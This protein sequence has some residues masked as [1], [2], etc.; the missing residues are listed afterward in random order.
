MKISDLVS[1]L[2]K[3]QQKHGDVNIR[4]QT[5]DLIASEVVA[6]DLET[7][8]HFKV[9][10]GNVLDVDISRVNIEDDGDYATIVPR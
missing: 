6:S 5:P 1:K 8:A 7:F 4:M 3:I 9:R 2:W 10:L